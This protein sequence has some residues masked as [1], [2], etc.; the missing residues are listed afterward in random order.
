MEQPKIID[1]VAYYEKLPDWAKQKYYEIIKG[2]CT[3]C[4]KYTVYRDMEAHRIKRG[5]H[6]GKYTL[7]KLNHPNQNVK[8][9]CKHCHKILHHAEPNMRRK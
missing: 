8:M 4:G 2:Y 9:V 6:G 5:C 7:C 3:L 1:G